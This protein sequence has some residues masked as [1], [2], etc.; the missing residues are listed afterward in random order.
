M[1][2]SQITEHSEV[3]SGHGFFFRGVGHFPTHSICNQRQPK[4]SEKLSHEN[5][6]HGHVDD[7]YNVPRALVWVPQCEFIMTISLSLIL[8]F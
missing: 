5:R 6:L 8:S 3:L 7:I 4:K 1:S 2:Y